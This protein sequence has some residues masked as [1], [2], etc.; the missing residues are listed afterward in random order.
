MTKL[1]HP[2]IEKQASTTVS[3]KFFHRFTI[4]S[5]EAQATLTITTDSPNFAEV[6]REL[7]G[8]AAD[9]GFY[10]FSIVQFQDLTGF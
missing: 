5:S 8:Q 4:A 10:C 1:A 7:M 9:R 6:Y 3:R 2:S